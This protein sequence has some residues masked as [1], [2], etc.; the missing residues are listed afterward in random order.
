MKNAYSAIILV[1]GSGSRMGACRN[2]IFLTLNGQA[3]FRYSLDLFLA[4]SD[5]QQVILVGKFDEKAHFEHLLSQRVQFVIGGSERQDSVRNALAVVTQ[6]TVMVH[7]GARPFVTASELSALKK[8][9]NAILAA[10]VK[11]TIKQIIDGK[12]LKT[13][14]REALWGAQTPQLFETA[15]IKKVH[16]MAHKAA[17]LGTDDASL[18]EQ[19]SDVSVTIVQGSYENIKMTTPEDL[20]FGQAILANR[21]DD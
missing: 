2:K 5:C 10:P 3:I 6:K 7:D 11:D 14:P 20:I 9:K 15:L 13:V 12:I 17:F 19:F 1:A 21:S 4:D 8:Q 18:V 16:E